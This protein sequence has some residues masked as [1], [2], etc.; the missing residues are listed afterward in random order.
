MPDRTARSAPARP[1][2]GR[3]SV[4]VITAFV[5]ILNE[6]VLSVA[7]PVLMTELSIS[8]VTAQWLSTGFM[9]TMA[10]V[11]PTTGFLL[12]RLSTRTV[13]T[14]AVTLFLV[15][16]VMG[17]V[18]IRNYTTPRRLRLDV[19]SVVLSAIGF[20]GVVYGLASMGQV[21][22]GSNR[23]RPVALFVLG[24]LALTGFVVRQTRLERTGGALLNLRPLT[25]HNFRASLLI[26]VVAMFTILGTVVVLP[27]CMTG[28]LG[29]STLQVGLLLLPGGLIQGVLGP[30]IGRLFDRVGPR[31]LAVPGMVLMTAA[32]WLQVFLLD[33]N[34]TAGLVVALN[35]VFGMGIASVMTLLMTLRPLPRPEPSVPARETAAV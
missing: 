33:E 23:I 25:V 7:L 15:G 28:S 27:I 13:F 5:M 12:K 35:V 3:W 4:L 10:V 24:L 31:P 11:I 2:R 16:T 30:V 17:L 34:A 9:L 18:Y 21:L 6:T 8:A 32:L 20:G 29:L 26:V 1:A 19:G 14:T 22:D